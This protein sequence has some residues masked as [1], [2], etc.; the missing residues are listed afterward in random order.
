MR[1]SLAPDCSSKS[2]A[3]KFVGIF[4]LRLQFSNRILVYPYVDIHTDMKSRPRQMRDQTARFGPRNPRRGKDLDG[5]FA[6]HRRKGCLY[7]ISGHPILSAYR[8][9][10]TCQV[11]FLAEV[12][13]KNLT[14]RRETMK[15]AKSRAWTM[16]R[17]AN[18]TPE[19]CR[20]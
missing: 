11:K 17:T 13:N 20:V 10:C 6:L 3:N 4:P 1:I 14:V 9:H 5:F 8:T 15:K 12:K 19:A 16:I 2:E 18:Q 7:A